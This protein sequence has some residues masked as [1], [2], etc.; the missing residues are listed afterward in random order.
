MRGLRDRLEAG[1]AELPGV[2]LFARDADRLPN[3][4]QFSLAG[5]DGEALLMQ[6]DREGIAVSS[7]SACASG[8][9]EPSHVL[10]AM[11][12]D[13]AT[14]R[15]AVRVSLGKDNTEADVDALLGALRRSIEWLGRTGAVGW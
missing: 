13:P 1:L 14:A 7:G 2:T 15:G 6:L 10:R 12:V 11:G 3:T 4:V 8:A 9:S 5:M